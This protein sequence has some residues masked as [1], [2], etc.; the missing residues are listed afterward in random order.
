MLFATFVTYKMSLHAPLRATADVSLELRKLMDCKRH[1]L[2]WRECHAFG[3][4]GTATTNTS[5]HFHL[6]CF[7]STKQD[8]NNLYVLVTLILQ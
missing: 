1:P 8:S 6:R 2:W 4:V 7:L 3:G 5:W